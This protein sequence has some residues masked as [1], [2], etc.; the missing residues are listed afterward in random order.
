MNLERFSDQ[1]LIKGF[2]EGNKECLEILIKK[3]QKKVYSYIFMTVKNQHVADDI[4]QE[5]FIKVV[6]SLKNGCYSD[7]GKFTSWVTRIAHNII[8]D[9]YRKEKAENTIS[10]DDSEVDFFNNQKYSDSTIEDLIVNE[11]IFEDVGKLIDYLPPEQKEI[12][13]LRH[14]SGMSFK[15]I[16]ELTN[17]SINT[18]L[19]RMRY[20]I[21]NLRRIVEEKQIILTK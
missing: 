5:T 8:I 13:I 20:A 3:H 7:Q 15:D 16:A 9:Y 10:N 12:I 2:N 21:I 17:V 19:G 6:N 18:A 14:Y 4:F 1:E 11:Q